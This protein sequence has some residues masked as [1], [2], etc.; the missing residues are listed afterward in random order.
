M[1]ENGFDEYKRLYEERFL[2]NEQ[3]HEQIIKRLDELTDA[4]QDLRTG[5]AGHSIKWS[6]VTTAVIIGLYVFLPS[7]AGGCH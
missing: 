1:G 7:L 4:V 3:Q 6:V 5:L 2:K